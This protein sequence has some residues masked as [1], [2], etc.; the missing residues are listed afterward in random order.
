MI[1]EF[2]RI[3][4]LVITPNEGACF[5]YRLKWPLMALFEEGKIELV[6][7]KSDRHHM[8]PDFVEWAHV[9]IFQFANPPYFVT[10]YA[11]I[12]KESPIPK[13]IICE[14]DDD[15]ISAQPENPAYKQFGTEEVYLKTFDENGN[16]EWL[17]KN[18][19]NR[20]DDDSG[21]FDIE[22]NKLRIAMLK[23]AVWNA[24]V[25]TMTTPRL[26]STFKNYAKRTQV[27]PNNI[28]PIPE[29]MPAGSKKERDYVLIG[30][31]GGD[32]H[33]FDLLSCI[34]TMKKIKDKYG[35][36]VKFRFMG[37]NF[38]M[39]YSV[40]DAEYVRPCEPKDFFRVFSEDTL[41]IGIVPLVDNQFNRSKSNI[42]WLE[43]SYYEIP[44]VVAHVPPYSD[45][46]EHGKTLLYY[47]TQS[48][49][50]KNLCKLIDSEVLRK[51]MGANA[52][53]YVLANY[54][55]RK[56]CHRWYDLFVEQLRLKYLEKLK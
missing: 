53:A 36:K 30:W 14:F 33:Y 46:G 55:I 37:A 8:F 12:L 56:N 17:Y 50:F 19:E 27:L 40:V 7:L 26:E 39:L 13:V 25:V 1:E 9:V 44:A 4:I 45:D 43:Y 41:D 16:R 6:V 5:F 28:Y 52:K 15:V 3:R 51:E 42:K 29:V 22:A 20:Y 10:E 49:L 35:D 21:P 38:P 11:R 48:Q 18:G 54:D 34:D 32:S 47:K 23:E 2:D 24:D 31:Q